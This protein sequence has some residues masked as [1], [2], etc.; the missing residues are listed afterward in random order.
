MRT[1]QT[2]DLWVQRIRH[3]LMKNRLRLVHQPVTSLN[4]DIDGVF[5]TRVRLLD[6]QDQLV[7]PS[8]FLPAA[9]RAGMVKNIDRWV[10]GASFS[11]CAAKHPTLVFVRLSRDSVVDPT[12]LDW[13]QARRR[14][15]RIKPGQICFQVAEEVAVQQLKQSKQLAEM[16]RGAG[17]RFAVDHIGNGR[18]SAGLIKHIPM[19]YVKIDGSLMQGL[20]LDKETQQT[21]GQLAQVAKD[22]GIRTIAE[23]VADAN[24]MAVLWQLGIAYIQGNYSQMRG[25]VLEDTMSVRSLNLSLAES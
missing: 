12:L 3:A 17:F 14:H 24:T 2:D 6:E 13:L 20:H 10:I 23:R 19:D 11:F 25:V 7:L 5:D 15:L 18:D 8:E 22:L 21:V 16:L 1:R 4:E 9:E